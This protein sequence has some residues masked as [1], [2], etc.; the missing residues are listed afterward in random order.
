MLEESRFYGQVGPCPSL[1]RECTG[2]LLFKTD[3]RHGSHHDGEQLA[4]PA[5]A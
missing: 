5:L 3:W 1:P 2:D 4:F